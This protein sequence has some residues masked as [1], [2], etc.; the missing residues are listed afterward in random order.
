M[1]C[2]SAVSEM[3]A[4]ICRV[5][6][7]PLSLPLTAH[8]LSEKMA[9]CFFNSL[10]PAHVHHAHIQQCMPMCLMLRSWPFI[11]SCPMLTI[12]LQKNRQAVPGRHLLTHLSNM[13]YFE[14]DTKVCKHMTACVHRS[15]LLHTDNNQPRNDIHNTW[16]LSLWCTTLQPSGH[17]LQHRVTATPTQQQLNKTGLKLPAALVSAT[18]SAVQ[19]TNQ[20]GD[21]MFCMPSC[22]T[23]TGLELFQK[24]S[25][26]HQSLHRQL[27]CMRRS[28]AAQ[29]CMSVRHTHLSQP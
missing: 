2:C 13:H 20:H 25:T 15:R 1:L 9:A 28:H 5:Y 10:R 3:V 4:T 17:N 27:V 12:L 6:A 26:D 7:F 8:T 23:T 24:Q 21:C 16:Q 19:T 14:I 18:T 29:I 22:T 11:Q